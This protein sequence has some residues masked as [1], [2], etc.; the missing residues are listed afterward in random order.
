M[1]IIWLKN[2]L[3][4]IEMIRFCLKKKKQAILKVT[5]WYDNRSEIVYDKSFPVI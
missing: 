1:D 5:N 2:W 4:Q 3:P